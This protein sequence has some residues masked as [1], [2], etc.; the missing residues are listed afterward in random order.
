MSP[1]YG[2]NRALGQA[3]QNARRWRERDDILLSGTNDPFLSSSPGPSGLTRR[4]RA[5]DFLRLDSRT[6]YRNT[7][8][9]ST[10]VCSSCVDELPAHQVPLASLTSGCSHKNSSCLACIQQWIETQLS[11]KGWDQI[12]CIG[13]TSIMAWSEIKQYAT[14]EVFER[15]DRLAARA[16]INEDDN[17]SW[18]PSGCGSG[19]V[20]EDR[21]RN[22]LFLCYNCGFQ[23]CEHF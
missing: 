17:F 3:V 4:E 2:G 15:Y 18:C 7:N 13:C 9:P 23:Y 1:Y 5:N 21:N 11:D 8:P 6:Q 20:H 10:R 14:T 19:Q 12:R 22:E 16:V